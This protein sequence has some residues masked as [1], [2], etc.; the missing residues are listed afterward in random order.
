VFDNGKMWTFEYP[1]LGYLQDTYGF[2]AD[3]EWFE[4][5]RLGALRIPGC[6]AS[7]V[8]PSGLVM[9]N[10]HCARESIEQV[11]RDGEDLVADGFYAASLEEE[12][13]IEDYWA[14]QLI[15]IRDVTDRVYAA[16][17]GVEGTEARG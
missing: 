6:T 11:S 4:K 9:T 17:E 3:A 8:S 16:L 10:H 1:P 13:P 2:S 15:E 7:F 14:D 5:A 12:R